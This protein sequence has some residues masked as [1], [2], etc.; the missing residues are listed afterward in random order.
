M[1]TECLELQLQLLTHGESRPAP[2]RAL[3]D[4]LV[5][6]ADTL[7]VARVAARAEEGEHIA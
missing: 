2:P 5:A 7:A 6:H 3:F 1:G 4:T